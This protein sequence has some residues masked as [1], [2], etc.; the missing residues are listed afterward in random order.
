MRRVTLVYVYIICIGMSLFIM[1]ACTDQNE[2]NDKSN[3][4]SEHKEK[5]KCPMECEGDKTYDE[6]G[7]CPV[8]G[9]DLK[10][11]SSKPVLSNKISDES[12]FNLSSKWV[13][14]NN[15][16][17]ILEDL[18]G[19]V[20]VMAMI[21]TSCKAACPRLVADMRNT[22][23]AVGTNPEVQYVFISIDP[24]TD[25]PAKLKTY[26]IQN[27]MDSPQWI[28]LNGSLED[29]REFANVLSVKYASISPVDFSHSN[30][31]SI[32]DQGGVLKYQEEGLGVENTGIVE[33][34]NQLTHI[35]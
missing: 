7:K 22:Q 16:E 20:L 32:F 3:S 18:K 35:D 33:T 14:Q 23:E 26:A 27:N 2:N 24:E 9:M 6:M 15:E 13:N 1:N 19:K 8:C 12:I 10:S 29:V 21:Y 11:S 31:I 17:L 30:I 25:T 34:I 4:V 5:F 28:F